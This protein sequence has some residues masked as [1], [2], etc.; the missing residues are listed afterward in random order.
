[1]KINETKYD[2]TFKTAKKIYEEKRGKK[3]C[4]QI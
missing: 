1:M 3:T 2:I 4:K